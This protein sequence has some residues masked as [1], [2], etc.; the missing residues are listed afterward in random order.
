MEPRVVLENH[1]ASYADPIEVAKGEPVS[2]TGREDIW[3][4][5][6]WFWAVA[7]DGREGW[8]P[9]DLITEID[10]RPTLSSSFGKPM[11]GPG[12]EIAT[13][14]KAGCRSEISRS[15]DLFC[16][17][18]PYLLPVRRRAMP[19]GRPRRASRNRM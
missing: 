18:A 3:D 10:E 15:D 14:A 12:V 2:L 13:A 4:G 19:R 6:R 11:V 17:H 16:R 7:D 8:V 9:D 5:H 1:G